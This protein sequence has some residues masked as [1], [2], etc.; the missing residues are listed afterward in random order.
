MKEDIFNSDTFEKLRVNPYAG[1][2]ERPP[3]IEPQDNDWKNRHRISAKLT[4]IN[5]RD[6]YKYCL[7]HGW[8]LS[9][10]INALIATHPKIN[11][12]FTKND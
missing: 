5:Y 7:E 12:I 1:L 8:N 9:S 2:R 4:A 11:K 6:F 10:G 3:G